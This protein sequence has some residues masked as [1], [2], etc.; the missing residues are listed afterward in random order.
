MIKQRVLIVGYGE[1]AMPCST[2]S[3]DTRHYPLMRLIQEIVLADSDVRKKWQHYLGGTF[4][5]H[6]QEKYP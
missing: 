1:M 3:S 6:F 2:F 4:R 5:N